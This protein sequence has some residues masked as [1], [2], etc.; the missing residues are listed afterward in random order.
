MDASFP[1][2]HYSDHTNFAT[3]FF[4]FPFPI[5]ATWTDNMIGEQSSSMSS[6]NA[7][8]N[9][10][11]PSTNSS[12]DMNSPV[13]VLASFPETFG[14]SD[15]MAALESSEFGMGFRGIAACDYKHQIFAPGEEF[16]LCPA[17]HMAA[18]RVYFYT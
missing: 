5:P 3:E 9:Y 11:F 13:S 8:I 2:P 6:N 14:V 10:K 1:D 18:T 17:Y 15:C 4:S 16:M 7:E 12:C